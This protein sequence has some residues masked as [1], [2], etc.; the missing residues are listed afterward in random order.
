MKQRFIKRRVE[1]RIKDLGW[2]RSMFY[3]MTRIGD[4]PLNA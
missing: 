2:D 3:T 4:L 1:E